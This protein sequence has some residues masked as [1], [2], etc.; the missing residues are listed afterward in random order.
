MEDILPYIGKNNEIPFIITEIE[1]NFEKEF[2]SLKILR[3]YFIESTKLC[4]S[5]A[6]TPL[7]IESEFSMENTNINIY[8][9]PMKEIVINI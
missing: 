4:E 3:Q 8:Q 2:E 7:K 5:F 6:E 1:M 9:K